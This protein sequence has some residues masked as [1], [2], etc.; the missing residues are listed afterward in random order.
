MTI[1]KTLVLSTTLLAAC[2]DSSPKVEAIEDAPSLVPITQPAVPSEGEMS[3]ADIFAERVKKRGALEAII[4]DEESFETFSYVLNK[5]FS[6]VLH[7]RDTSLGPNYQRGGSYDSLLKSLR[8]AE[9]E[10]GDDI[11]NPILETL[12]DPKMLI[13]FC[14]MWCEKALSNMPDGHI[15]KLDVRLDEAF[16]L[17][18]LAKLPGFKEL[19]RFVWFAEKA[20]NETPQ[21]DLEERNTIQKRVVLRA[22]ADLLEFCKSYLD[23][24]IDYRSCRA[25]YRHFSRNPEDWERLF[26]KLERKIDYYVPPYN[27]ELFK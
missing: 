1:K 7:H 19:N 2:A 17:L 26:R 12:K 4:S 5:E 15:I 8:A 9:K 23:V 24:S 13:E 11:Y 16:K 22:E 21:S 14:E 10:L 27:K 25:I 6:S 18:S 3:P 20:R